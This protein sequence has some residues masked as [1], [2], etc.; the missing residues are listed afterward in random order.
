MYFNGEEGPRSLSDFQQQ[1]KINE[2]ELAIESLTGEKDAITC[3]RKS[4]EDVVVAKDTEISGLIGIIEGLESKIG[5]L[6]GYYEE[7][8]KKVLE[9]SVADKHK[10]FSDMDTC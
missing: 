7:K 6:T 8:S 4:V 5:A 10:S 2:L 1:Q 3:D 9:E